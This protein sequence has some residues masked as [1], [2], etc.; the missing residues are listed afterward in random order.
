[1]FRAAVLA[2]CCVALLAIA[3]VPVQ[4]AAIPAWLDESISK[5]NEANADLPIRFV[6]IKDSF[7]WYDLPKSPEIGHKRVRD[8]VSRLVLE[9][10]YVPMDEEELVTTAN[11]PVVSG[12]VTPKKCWK[13]SYVMNI[14]SQSNTKSVDDEHAGQRQRMLTSLVCEDAANWW[15]A[16]R[17]LQ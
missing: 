12:P 14:Q 2:A 13:W 17:V 5:W 10:G 6:N 11:P 16:F 4:A 15:A 3:A 1:M 9:N 7:V 8:A